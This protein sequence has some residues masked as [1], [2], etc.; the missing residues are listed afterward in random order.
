[1]TAS[2][3]S[4]FLF[5]NLN[6]II[7]LLIPAFLFL[8]REKRRDRFLLRLLVL[9]PVFVGMYF[10][11]S[12][13]LGPFLLT[14]L[15]SFAAA[16]LLLLFFFRIS[17][18]TS[19]F[20][21]TGAFALQHIA[22]NLQFIIY[23][24]TAGIANPLALIVYF[25]VFI[26]VYGLAG[27]LFPTDVLENIGSETV[28]LQL[29]IS[30][31]IL[32]VTYC[33]SCLVDYYDDMNIFIRIYACLCCLF[34][35]LVQF[36]FLDRSR[37]A[38]QKKKA[39]EDIL[40]LQELWNRERRQYHF[41]KESIEAVNIKCHDLKNQLTLLKSMNEKERLESIRRLEEEVMIY[42]GFAKTG[43]D[44][45]DVVLTEKMLY[46]EKNRIRLTYIAAGESIAF[47]NPID[48]ASL[49]G[50]TLDNAIESVMAEAR[51]EKRIIRLNI[52]P[53]RSFVSIHL[54]NY[55][56][57]ERTFED[58]LPVSTKKDGKRHGYGT[59]SI[60]RIVEQY[61][62]AVHFRQEGFIFITEIVLPAKEN[63]RAADSSQ[64]ENDEEKE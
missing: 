28:P 53:H 39:E 51:D 46:C 33:L 20:V 17:A 48:I 21:M 30:A 24:T 6:A 29:L 11:P 54:E 32:I 35:I 8:R 55:C 5:G 41:S 61:G 3:Y 63:D 42:G 38:R 44:A 18:Y 2:Y 25:L 1:M 58:G 26:V 13:N 45:L 4:L 43:N 59:L 7:E 14:F 62:G 36:G 56:S 49:F 47:L 52:S 16:F 50:N 60:R 34:A 22:W 23:E 40:I 19:L 15:V 9:I 12:I 64:T 31:L 57:T 10:L 27:V 37:L